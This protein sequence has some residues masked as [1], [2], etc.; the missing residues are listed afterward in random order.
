MEKKSNAEKIRL[1]AKDQSFWPLMEGA[2][3]DILTP[4]E[5]AAVIAKMKKVGVT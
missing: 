2:L 1:E 5:T 4:A 3:S